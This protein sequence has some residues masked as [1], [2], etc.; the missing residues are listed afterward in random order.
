MM[1]ES[2]IHAIP[3]VPGTALGVLGIGA[4]SAT[5]DGLVLLHW[6]EIKQFT[7]LPTRV[8]VMGYAPLAHPMIRLLGLGVPTVVISAQQA[9]ALQAGQRLM[10][11]GHRG[12]IR[13]AGEGGASRSYHAAAE[14]R[15]AVTN[16][17][18]YSG[19][20]AH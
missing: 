13:D 1:L 5:P 17:R 3:Y 12:V 7:T 6:Q 2:D 9:E 16:T 11:D 14:I 19:C 4:A 15:R 18:W 20:I 8:I 10:V